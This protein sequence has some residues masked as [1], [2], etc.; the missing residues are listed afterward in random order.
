M[1]ILAI[2]TSSPY[3][4]VSL[5][6]NDKPIISIINHIPFR[7]VE[8]LPIFVE[9][10]LGIV[11]LSFNDLSFIA[12]S[13]GPGFFTSLRAG[14]SYA[15]AISFSLEIPVLP[16][17]TMEVIQKEYG[18]ENIEVCF[19]LKGEKVFHQRFENGMPKGEIELTTLKEIESKYP[20]LVK[21]DAILPHLVGILA[22]KKYIK[23]KA[24][25]PT[26]DE[27]EPKYIQAPHVN[28]PSPKKGKK[29]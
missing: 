5:L 23:G 26:L 4:G 13:E 25:I 9:R 10:L 8:E 19:R 11:G 21:E 3:T 6:K 20:I 7:H 28:Y 12:V 16:V 22:Y 27:V 15:R 2:E 29:I 1:N 18:I 24:K 17:S 14:I